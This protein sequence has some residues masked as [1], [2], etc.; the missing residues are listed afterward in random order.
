MVL[1]GGGRRVVAHL[2][3]SPEVGTK[4]DLGGACSNE[5]CGGEVL[6]PRLRG[7]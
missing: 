6:S 1:S 4:A 5:A 7:L 3:A 2:V